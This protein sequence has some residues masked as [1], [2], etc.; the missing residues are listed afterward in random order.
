MARRGD[1][2]DEASA[3]DVSV[4][5]RRV[6]T[7]EADKASLESQLR[8]ARGDRGKTIDIGLYEGLRN[9]GRAFLGALDG[10]SLRQVG[11]TTALDDFREAL[12]EDK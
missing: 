9:A 12:G 2:E 3:A 5:L 8:V 10:D 11:S 6:R 4:L 7:L 1:W